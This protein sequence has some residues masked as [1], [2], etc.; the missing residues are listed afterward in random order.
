M[1]QALLVSLPLAFKTARQLE[2]LGPDFFVEVHEHI[3]LEPG[4]SVL[5]SDA[6]VMPVQPVYQ[7]LDAGFV[8]MAQV[9]GGLSRFL[10]HHEGLGG[11]EAECVDYHFPLDGLDGI[12]HY[13]DGAGGEL[14]EGLLGV[15]VDGGEPASEPRMRV[16]PS[17]YD[18]WS[19]GIF[20]QRS[21][22]L[23]R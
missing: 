16:V 10:A 12:D 4:F 22:A 3:L 15:D 5:D 23:S 19:A 9:G 11:D 7:G 13:S 8:E 18:F 14:F 1:S 21:S 6:V 20:S 2:A 17:N